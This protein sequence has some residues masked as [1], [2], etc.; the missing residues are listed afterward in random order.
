MILL[1]ILWLGTFV[2]EIVRKA[3]LPS[4]TKENRN[5]ISEGKELR[6]AWFTKFDSTEYR[7][8]CEMVHQRH[9]MIL[10]S[11]AKDN[12]LTW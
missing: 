5:G 12:I 2:Y 6:R 8:Q 1:A 9:M 4:L 11:T 10:K 3:E 7:V